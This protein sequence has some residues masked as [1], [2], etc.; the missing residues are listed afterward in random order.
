MKRRKKAK[1]NRLTNRRKELGL[2]GA[3][4]A[5]RV[6][7]TPAH[8]HDI[9]SG[10]ITAPGVHVALRLAETLSVDIR[11]LFEGAA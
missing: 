4:L 9:E 5:R 8:L 3:E 6:G 10:R 1:S 7:I 11:E 2:S